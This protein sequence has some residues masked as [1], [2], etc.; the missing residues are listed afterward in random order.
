MINEL[1]VSTLKSL[2]IP[3]V[4]QSYNTDNKPPAYVIFSI[5]NEADT[6][7]ADDINDSE[8]YYITLNYWFQNPSDN[9]KAKQI[10]N[11]MKQAGF[12]FDGANDLTGQ[13][14]YGKNLDFIY[15]IYL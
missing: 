7:I 14:S 15:K 8:T 9:S 3:I 5:Y 13:T 1:V 4:Y 6:D 2:N 11:L 12:I 10:K